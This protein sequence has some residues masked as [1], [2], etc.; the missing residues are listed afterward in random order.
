MLL[1]FLPPPPTSTHPNT[2][3]PAN[4]TRTPP[5]P[6]PNPTRTPPQPH[7]PLFMIDDD[8]EFYAD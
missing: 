7:P 6:H 3:I 4:P 1:N 8:K 5:E 2:P